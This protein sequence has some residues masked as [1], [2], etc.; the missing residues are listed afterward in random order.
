MEDEVAMLYIKL[1]GTSSWK[2]RF[3]WLR[4]W[5]WQSTTWYD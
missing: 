3:R 5:I 2:Y 1:K 4:W